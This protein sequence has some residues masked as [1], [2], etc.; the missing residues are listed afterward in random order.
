MLTDVIKGLEFKD[1][2]LHVFLSPQKLTAILP[3]EEDPYKRSS[4]IAM[5]L[6]HSMLDRGLYVN[7]M[8]F[9]EVPKPKDPLLMHHEIHPGKFNL[10]LRL[11]YLPAIGD[12]NVS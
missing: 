2:P 7:D 9:Y 3:T 11:Y 10:H 6:L 1:M 5:L 8:E 12:I 4:I